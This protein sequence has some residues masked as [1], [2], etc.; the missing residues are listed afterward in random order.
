MANKEE[1]QNEQSSLNYVLIG[2][3]L[4]AG[5]GLL[6][7]SDKGKKVLRTVATSQVMKMVGSELT[8][9]V[10]DMV[11]EQAVGSVKKSISSYIQKAE[12]KIPLPIPNKVTEKLEEKIGLNENDED[13]E[14]TSEAEEEAAPTEEE[15]E[16][17]SSEDYDELKEENK[18]LNERLDKIEEMLT[19]LADSK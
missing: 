2:S 15:Y 17:S 1:Q 9:S 4:G 13:E 3:A 16:E 19:K 5:A 8:K 12:N 6:S 10:Q 14:T 18:N 11:T 7:S